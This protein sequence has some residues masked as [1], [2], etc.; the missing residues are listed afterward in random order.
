MTA[1]AYLTSQLPVFNDD[2]DDTSCSGRIQSLLVNQRCAAGKL[3]GTGRRSTRPATT[4]R[5]P[6]ERAGTIA[7]GSVRSC[8]AARGTSSMGTHPLLATGQIPFRARSV[9]IY[10]V[11]A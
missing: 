10:S 11:A 2:G 8:A 9:Q 6:G 4:Y 7:F 5:Q 1:G 3:D